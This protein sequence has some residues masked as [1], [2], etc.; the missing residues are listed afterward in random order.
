MPEETWEN[1]FLRVEEVLRELALNRHADLTADDL[2]TLAIRVQQIR[3]LEH[4]RTVARGKPPMRVIWDDED[5]V[6][7]PFAGDEGALP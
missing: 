4:Q 1:I 5:Y 6:D 2:R 3:M 7:D